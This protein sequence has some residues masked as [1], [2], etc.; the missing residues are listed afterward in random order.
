MITAPVAGEYFAAHDDE[1]GI[2]VRTRAAGLPEGTTAV[3][4]RVTG[5]DEA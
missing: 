4:G 3:I 1:Y 5:E 2:A